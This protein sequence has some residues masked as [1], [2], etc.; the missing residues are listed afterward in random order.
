MPGGLANVSLP[1]PIQPA[2]GSGVPGG[3]LCATVSLVAA[4]FAVVG[5]RSTELIRLGLATLRNTWAPVREA[6]RGP[7]VSRL[8]GGFGSYPCEDVWTSA[9]HF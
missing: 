2:I 3:R 9:A 5:A 8:G 6:S 7:F 1:A 4:R